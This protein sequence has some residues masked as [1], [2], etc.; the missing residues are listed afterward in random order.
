M[1]FSG[2]QRDGLIKLYNPSGEN[3][4][5]AVRVYRRNHKLKRGPYS[6][7]SIHNLVK[8][9]EEPGCTC[10]KSLSGRP[11]VLVEVVAEVHNTMTTGPLILQE[12]FPTILDVPKTTVLKILCSVLRMFPYRF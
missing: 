4:A 8:K 12:V 5:E 6:V 11:R 10:D 7:Q 1:A 3:A 9:F 2:K